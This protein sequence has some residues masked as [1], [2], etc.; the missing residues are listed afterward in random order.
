MIAFIRWAAAHSPGWSWLINVK[1]CGN[2]FPVQPLFQEV[3]GNDLIFIS[4]F[5]PWSILSSGQA[6]RFLISCSFDISILSV[7]VINKVIITKIINFLVDLLA[8]ITWV[9]DKDFTVGSA[10]SEVLGAVLSFVSSVLLSC[11]H[12]ETPK[13]LWNTWCVV[14]LP[15]G[16]SVSNHKSFQF[17]LCSNWWNNINIVGSVFLVGLVDLPGQVWNVDS[18][19]TLSGKIQIVS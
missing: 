3:S 17:V 7:V 11:D 9:F 8:S 10:T 14:I 6:L 1:S 18:S 12:I 16:G 4:I 13:S 5:H 19:I 2:I 15:V